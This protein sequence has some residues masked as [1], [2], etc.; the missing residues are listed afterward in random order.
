MQTD[1]LNDSLDLPTQ[2]IDGDHLDSENRT[3]TQQF[4]INTMESATIVEESDSASDLDV[5]DPSRIYSELNDSGTNHQDHVID[6][7]VGLTSFNVEKITEDGKNSYR[8]VIADIPGIVEGAHEGKGL[9][10]D[11][12]KHIQKCHILVHIIDASS[13]VIYTAHL[14]SI[15]GLSNCY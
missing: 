1:L 3:Y 13:K 15:E 12:L 14:G 10:L 9:G 7:M 11:F 8:M 5:N 2:L 4:G 6:D